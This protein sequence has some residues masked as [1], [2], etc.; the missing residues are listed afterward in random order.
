MKKEYTFEG[1]FK[2]A[3]VQRPDRKYG[4]YRL[5]FYPADAPTRKAI[6]ETGTQCH[7]KEDDDGFFYSFKSEIQPAV[8]D[9]QGN[10][11]TALVGNGSKGVVRIMVE[12]FTSAKYGEIARTKLTGVVVTDLIEFVPKTQDAPAPIPEASDIPA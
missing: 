8:T 7:V 11:I 10:P 4:D 3:Q 5:T 6:K 1:M 9:A 12:K 2:W